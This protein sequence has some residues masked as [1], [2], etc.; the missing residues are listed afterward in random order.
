MDFKIKK[1]TIIETDSEIKKKRAA[2]I[3]NKVKHYKSNASSISKGCK[4]KN[5][6]SKTCRIYIPSTG[7]KYEMCEELHK[8]VKVYLNRNFKK[9]KNNLDFTKK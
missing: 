5:T 6:K 7:K 2:N 1:I 4:K 9:M 3:I 8:E